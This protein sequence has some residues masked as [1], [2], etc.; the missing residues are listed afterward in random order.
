MLLGLEGQN[1]I[2]P[3]FPLRHLYV[4]LR[5]DLCFT[6]VGH[7]SGRSENIA[8]L[9]FVVLRSR[10]Q[11]LTVLSNPPHEL[12]PHPCSR[13]YDVSYERHSRKQL[14]LPFSAAKLSQA[15]FSLM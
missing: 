15:Y 13:N 8:E 3:T 7:K 4:P 11:I 5:P 14:S 1:R 2:A 12:L 9:R 6:I 10:I